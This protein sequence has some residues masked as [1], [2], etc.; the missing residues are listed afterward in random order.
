MLKKTYVCNRCKKESPHGESLLS[1]LP[2]NWI[3][4]TMSGKSCMH[5]GIHLCPECKNFFIE[6]KILPEVQTGESPNSDNI[7]N[8]LI[9]ILEEIALNAVEGEF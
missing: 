8:R 3:Y 2:K 6:R 9:A 5:V 7:P 1:S 4:F